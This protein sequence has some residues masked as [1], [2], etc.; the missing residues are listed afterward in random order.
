MVE[1]VVSR[2]VVCPFCA[3]ACDDLE[4][5]ARG[6][7]LRVTAKG[8]ERAKTAFARSTAEPEPAIDGRAC[9]LGEA[10]DRAADLLAASRLP[11]FAG[12]ATDTAGMRAVMALAEATGGILDHAQAPGLFA[13]LLAMQSVGWFTATLAEARNR[14]DFVLL[15]GGDGSE[16]APRLHERVLRPPRS[17]RGQGAP[18]RIVQLGGAPGAGA[19][20]EHVPCP[21][22]RLLEAVGALRGLLA[23]ARLPAAAHALLPAGALDGLASALREAD[24]ALVVWAAGAMGMPHRELLVEHLAELLKELNAKGRAAGLPLAGPGNVIGANQVC[25]WQS[26]VPLRTGFAGGV[27]DYQP[28]R[29]AAESLLAAGS[30]DTLVWISGFTPEPAPATD[31]PRLL[32]TTPLDAPPARGV[33]LPLATPGLDHAGTLYRTDSVVAMPVRAL[34]PSRLPPAADVLDLLRARLDATPRT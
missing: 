34:R 19:G 6:R 23:G 12:L 11:L 26:G 27:P 21:A 17:L 22:D 4:I 2:D 28:H 31:L 9:S 5:E 18:R 8:C 16:A 10:L 32:L 1:R 33:Y 20:I 14:P 13:N 30:V 3:L 29:F 15:V 7:A 24:Y 25:A